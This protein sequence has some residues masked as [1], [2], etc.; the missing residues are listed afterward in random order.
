M[1][2]PEN[3]QRIGVSLQKIPS[4]KRLHNYGKSPFIIGRSTINGP[5]SIV[6]CMFT[7]G[8]MIS[9]WGISESIEI[10]LDRCGRNI[11]TETYGGF[12]SH[13]GTPSYHPFIDGFSLNYAFWGIPMYGNP[14]TDSN[15]D[16][17]VKIRC[18]NS[19]YID[20]LTIGIVQCI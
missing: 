8:Y 18:Q 20:H 17:R 11:H 12:L 10:W 2:Y 9:N 6:F 14:Q 19:R 13:G 5:I 7:R 1:K 15:L 16:S 4:G 3:E